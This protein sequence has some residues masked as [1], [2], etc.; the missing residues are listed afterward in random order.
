MLPGLFAQI[1]TGS[2][3]L[4][5]RDEDGRPIRSAAVKLERPARGFA[6]SAL[7]G[8]DGEA[9]FSLLKPGDDYEV[10]VSAPAFVSRT[11][12]PLT[13]QLGSA[14]AIDATLSVET[15]TFRTSVV[16]LLPESVDPVRSSP[17]TVIERASIDNLPINRRNYLDFSLLTPG[18]TQ[19]AVLPDGADFRAKIG[20][21]A[22]I[23]F[24]GSGGR[25][26]SFSID[27]VSIVGY[28][29]N[30]RPSLPQSAVQEFQVMRTGYPVEV[31][32]ASGGAVNIVSRSG[33]NGFHGAAF[34]FV[35]DRAFQARNFFDPGKS[36]YTRVQSGVD[37]SGP[38]RRDR[39]FFFAA[40]ERLDRHE[41][42]F[43][44][45][46]SDPSALSRLS[47]SQTNLFN[48]LSQ[49]GVPALQA[50]S[51]GMRQALTPSNSPLLA[52]LFRANSGSFPFRGANSQ[53]SLRLDHSL[54]ARQ[55]LFFRFSITRDDEQ[56]T[57]FGAQEGWSTG[58]AVVNNDQTVV[59]GDRYNIS[60]NWYAVLRGGF[61]S[62]DMR[63]TPN[64]PLGPNIQIAG[65]GTFGRD[66]FSPFR[67]P[68]RY[69]QFQPQFSYMNGR[70]TL[71]FGGDLNWIQTRA[72]VQTYFGGRFVFGAGIPLSAVIDAATQ[73]PGFSAQL[74]A[75]LASLGQPALAAGVNDPIN[76]LQGYALG[77][78]LAYFQG[79]GGS[80]YNVWRQQHAAYL[81]DTFRTKRSLTITVG[82][83]YQGLVPPWIESRQNL[84]PRFGFAWS[85][86]S[87]SNWVVRGGYGLFYDTV[88]STMAYGDYQFKRP[89]YN[90]VLIPIT[91]VPGVINPLT[92]APVTSVDVYQRVAATGVL[93]SRTIQLSDLA[94]VGIPP[95]FR[96]PLIGGVQKD[97]HVPMAQQAHLGVEHGFRN[98]LVSAGLEW[99]RGEHAWRGIDI[100]VIQTGVRPDG[101]PIFGRK[102]PTIANNYLYETSASSFYWAMVLQAQKRFSRHWSFNLNYTLS[103]ATDEV[104]D[105]LPDYG[106]QN[107]LDLRAER[108]L[109]LFHRKHRF[110]GSAVFESAKSGG[111]LGGW[112]LAPIVRA[113]SFAPFN[114]LTGVDILGDG[115]V[116]THRPLG[117]GR[118]AGIGPDSFTCDFRLTRSF[119]LLRERAL[120]VQAI[121][122]VF[123]LFN[124]A[125]F[126]SVNNIVGPAP[127]SAL[128]APLQAHRGMPTDPLVYTS[129]FDARQFQLGLRFRF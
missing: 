79:F 72:D 69:F 116:N 28:S 38:I 21:P 3:L 77:L 24:S 108:G 125:N 113:T 117:L 97:Y 48:Y 58:S 93:G 51:A 57:R 127:L 7:A 60:P 35:R 81:E 90:L 32:F 82:L 68:E 91:G 26:G 75:M 102:D 23:G 94:A 112:I 29:G 43:V 53:G 44:P 14:L 115:Q 86:G 50:L 107:Q 70:H 22:G 129:A 36:A 56:N 95:G 92:N 37:V 83:C 8:A 99:S 111:L 101:W 105:Y 16:E 34:G 62:T 80:A 124:R 122:E 4:R 6:A 74:E 119:T 1:D 61:G 47:P 13:V 55:N 20:P 41:T 100:N 96:F 33:Q 45:I 12:A 109:S 78:P 19:T 15:P 5:V 89:D 49:T 87:L 66:L 98:L 42:V 2:V 40:F 18:V 9:R 63:F 120:A 121:G 64:D 54:T 11:F 128:P 88:I 46:L 31:G 114:V 103:R 39:T 59:F 84:A 106:P 71:K 110:I 10:S 85:P 52:S 25:N 123:N 126:E 17:A 30:V 67:Q 73:T 118:N 104:S 27:G 76:G 65:Y